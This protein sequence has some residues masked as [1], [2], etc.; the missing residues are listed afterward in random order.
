MARVDNTSFYNLS[1]KKYKKTAM[2]VHWASEARQTLRFKIFKHLL[3][4]RLHES[5]IVDAGCGFAD[6]YRYLKKEKVLPL[7]YIGLD[8]H[9]NMVKLARKSTKQRILHVDVLT[10]VLP[11]ADYYICS[12][13]MNLLEPFETLLFIKQMLR[14]ANKGVLFNILKG[15]DDSDTY[16]KYLPQQMREALSFFSGDIEIIE[17]YLDDDFTV[18]MQKSAF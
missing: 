7:E 6:L 5:C 15:D 16:N 12:G 9:P 8:S 13:A 2:G 11:Q 14:Y 4:K 1:I 10:A 3:E 18:F 17:D